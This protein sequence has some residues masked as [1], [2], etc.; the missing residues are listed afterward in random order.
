MFNLEK[1]FATIQQVADVIKA[2]REMFEAIQKPIL[3]NKTDIE[4]LKARVKE[5]EQKGEEIN[6]DIPF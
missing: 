2:I 3:Q 1:K 5:L 6:D 4:L